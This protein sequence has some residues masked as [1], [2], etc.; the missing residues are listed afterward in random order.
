MQGA[1]DHEELRKQME[2]GYVGRRDGS[3]HLGGCSGP[4]GR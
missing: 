2:V 1:G 3:H 4:A